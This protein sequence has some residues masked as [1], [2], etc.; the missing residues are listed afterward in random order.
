MPSLAVRYPSLELGLLVLL[1]ALLGGCG[2]DDTAVSEVQLALEVIDDRGTPLPG[3]PL[4]LDGARA[5]VTDAR[6]QARTLVQARRGRRVELRPA[7]S[8]QYR[9]SEARSVLLSSRGERRAPLTLRLVCA[10]LERTLAVVVRA[11][12]GAGFPLR[13]DGQVIATIGEDGLAHALLRRAP[14]TTLRL[15]LDTGSAPRVLPQF[16]AREVHVA[17]RDEIVVFDQAFTQAPAVR[18]PAR[19]PRPSPNRHEKRLPYAIGRAD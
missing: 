17:D 13:A 15:S 16:P 18:I 6:G 8:S 12:G 4:L 10:P 19:L 5:T 1:S 14:D 7:C 3:V 2:V 9:R 11:P